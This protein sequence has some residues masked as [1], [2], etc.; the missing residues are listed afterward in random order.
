MNKLELK[1]IIPAPIVPM[2]KDYEIDE[3]DLR[4][5]IHWLLEQEPEG[6]AINVDTGEGVHL[7][8]EER[9]KVIRI[10]AEEI[11]GEIPII[12]GLGASFTKQG[13]DLAKDAKEAGADAVLVFPIPVYQGTT[14]D[15]EIPFQ[16]HKAIAEE[17]D[18]PLVLFRLQKA[19]AGKEYEIETIE[20]LIKIEGVVAI[21]EATFNAVKFKELSSFLKGSN[22]SLLT[23]NDNFLYESFLLGANGGLLGI[24]ALGI[25]ELKAMQKSVKERNY[26]IG[27]NVS[28]KFQPFSDFIF[29]TPVRDYR[30]RIKEALVIMG[31][32]KNSF[33]RPPLLPLKAE[34]K[35]KIKR[36]MIRAELL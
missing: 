32:I 36:E 15:P 29:S 26:E 4:N 33:V 27:L 16:Y 11:R 28:D 19:L 35:E 17:A 6:V 21:K 10:W 1:G 24:G 13:I 12:A 23:G 3:D 31:V 34:E 30:A 2:T 25:K 20:K 7:Y 14:L 18:I 9:N 8:P 22:I 5:Y